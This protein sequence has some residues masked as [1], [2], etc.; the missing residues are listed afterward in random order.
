MNHYFLIFELLF[1]FFTSVFCEESFLLASQKSGG[2]SETE[3]AEFAGK[4][5]HLKSFTSC[6]WEKLHFFN[7][8]SHSIWNYCTVKKIGDTMEC[9]QMWASREGF[10]GGSLFWKG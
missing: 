9:I 10:E 1:I 8:K 6:H 4:M 5:P 2:T 7:I 3:W